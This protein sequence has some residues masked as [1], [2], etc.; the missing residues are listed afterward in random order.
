MENRIH[1][2]IELRFRLEYGKIV[3]AE[4][5][6]T[7]GWRSGS[8][9]ALQAEGHKFKSC[10][11]H[12]KQEDPGNARVLSHSESEPVDYSASTDSSVETFF[13]TTRLTTF[14]GSSLKTPS[15]AAAAFSA[16][17]SVRDRHARP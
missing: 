13:F 16:Q 5:S 8:A 15:T 1:S 12:Q 2:A 6:T 10:T 7:A 14:L 4:Y 9:A 11:G 17:F 3:H